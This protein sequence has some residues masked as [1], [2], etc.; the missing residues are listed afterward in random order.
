MTFRAKP[1]VKRAQR[2]S[3]ES[4]DRR[5]FYLNLGFG[6]VV[7]AAVLMLA[8][9]FAISYYNEHLASVGSVAGQS[10]TRDDLNDRGI[11]E[12]WRLDEAERRVSTQVVA[13]RLSQAQSD[14][15]AQFIDQQ[16]T[17]LAAIAL[18]RIIDNRVQADLAAKEGVTVTE[19]DIDARL[20]VE[21]TVLETRHV[22]HIE[23][24]PE[25]SPGATVPTEA[26]I[27]AAKTKIDAALADLNSGKSWDDIAKTVSTDSATAPQAGDLGW[28]QAEDN[29]TDAAFLEAV[30]AAEV[31]K[32]TPV[33]EGADGIFRIG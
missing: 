17:N 13:G 33:I 23:V 7:V 16:R 25:I 15:Q 2:P 11:I 1:V 21:A 27:A 10:I 24:A 22:W 29:Q 5:N 8:I 6:V 19:A 18:E 28:L 12:S 32:P 14:L 20:V 31:D 26:Q 30:F 9:A 3:W 4:R